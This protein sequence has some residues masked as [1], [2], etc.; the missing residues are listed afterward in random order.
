MIATCYSNSFRSSLEMLI[1][2][3]MYRN[4]CVDDSNC[5]TDRTKHRNV[6]AFFVS[7]LRPDSSLTIH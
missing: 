3:R 7:D 4:S 2:G 1:Q 6:N 5:Q